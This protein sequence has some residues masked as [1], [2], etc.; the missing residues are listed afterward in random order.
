MSTDFR[1]ADKEKTKKSKSILNTFIYVSVV[2]KNKYASAKNYGLPPASVFI[3]KSWMSK[4]SFDSGQKHKNKE[5]SQGSKRRKKSESS[6]I[7]KDCL[8]LL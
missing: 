8:I 2:L 1:S 3:S 4:A 6:G 7:S 5:P